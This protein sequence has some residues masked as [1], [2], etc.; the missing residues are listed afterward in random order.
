MRSKFNSMLKLE[1]SSTN[2]HSKPNYFTYQT[3][4]FS[5][6]SLALSFIQSVFT[7]VKSTTERETE[8]EQ[9]F[10]LCRADTAGKAGSCAATCHG[11]SPRLTTPAGPSKH[12]SLIFPL[13]LSIPSAS[14]L[15]YTED[16]SNLRVLV[17]WDQEEQRVGRIR[18]VHPEGLWLLEG[19]S[20]VG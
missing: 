9:L 3:S 1:I 16:R 13:S 10:S 7:I 2:A 12:L 6:E 17:Q 8:G 19:C 15:N 20:G 5:E 18:R 4:R 11:A 14:S